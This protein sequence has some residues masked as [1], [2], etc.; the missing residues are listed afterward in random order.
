MKKTRSIIAVLLTLA[1]VLAVGIPGIAAGIGFFPGDDNRY[2]IQP[3]KHYDTYT[4]YGD[5]ITAGVNCKD[6]YRYYNKDGS[7][8]SSASYSSE[9][10]A[11]A[12]HWD[13]GD[14][15]RV[16]GTYPALVEDMVTADTVNHFSR[17]GY[18]SDEL[19]ILLDDDYYGDDLTPTLLNF[20]GETYYVSIDDWIKNRPAFQQAA[21]DADLITLGI[22]SND[23][24]MTV[25]FKAIGL[26]YGENASLG[27]IANAIGS[28]AQNS[29]DPTNMMSA[30][31]QLMNSAFGATKTLAELAQAM[32]EAEIDFRTNFKA[33]TDRIY[34]LNPDVELVVVGVY[35][36]AKEIRVS[37]EI[38]L[39]AGKLGDA[40]FMAINNYIANLCPNRTKYKYVDVWNITLGEAPSLFDMIQNIGL[41][42][43]LMTVDHP[44]ETGH[45]EIAKEIRAVLPKVDETTQTTP[46]ETKAEE[47]KAEE[48]KAEEAKAAET[49]ANEAK[50]NETKAN[51][52]LTRYVKKN[53]E[54]G[55]W[56][57][58]MGDDIEWSYT[59]IAP[60]QYGWW[61][62]V[63]G[64][65]DFSANSIYK[66]EF[67]W[68]K[69]TNGKVTFD[70][71]EI[72]SNQY[73]WWKCTDSK[74]TFQETGIFKNKF[75]KWYCKDSKVDFNKNGKVKYNGKTYTVKNGK[76]A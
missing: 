28:I 33:I 76:V 42:G 65:V 43:T 49:K 8:E 71:N 29:Q 21:V 66:N 64:E 9:M 45:A 5:S 67:G 22:G 62:I 72:Y 11:A 20:L 52:T 40:A 70:E 74:V 17:I 55:K 14:T 26:L 36:G 37:N 75:G 48:T 3:V 54:D 24:L 63:N 47:T 19:R 6:Y 7:Y 50:A 39:Q 61:R 57:C 51:E 1:I 25:W 30:V 23:V 2:T 69:C 4:I 12:D 35:N 27:T 16:E 59:G 18:R 46:K 53:P 31:L 13:R 44:T 32:L 41:I 10:A 38:D 58:Y 56:Y 34:E 73:G 15:R 60:N 68:W